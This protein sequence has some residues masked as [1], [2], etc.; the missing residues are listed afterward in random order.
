MAHRRA[1]PHGEVAEALGQVRETRAAPRRP[2][3]RSSSR[4]SPPAVATRGAGLPRA[5]FPPG[6]RRIPGGDR[7]GAAR[8]RPERPRRRGAW[9][10]WCWFPCRP[11]AV[12]L[13]REILRRRWRP[14]GRGSPTGQRRC[15]RHGGGKKAWV[16]YPT[17]TRRGACGRRAA[18]AGRFA[19]GVRRKA[20]DLLGSIYLTSQNSTV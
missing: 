19:P 15:P 3:S 2:S 13:A 9:R 10:T 1:L 5:N 7:H 20:A 16:V 8:R 6:R 17:K 18:L 12:D 11:S 4:H 14:S